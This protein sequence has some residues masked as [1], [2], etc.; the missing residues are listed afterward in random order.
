MYIKTKNHTYGYEWVPWKIFFFT[1]SPIICQTC[2]LDTAF[3]SGY[4]FSN[5]PFSVGPSITGASVSISHLIRDQILM[6]DPDMRVK[7]QVPKSLSQSVASDSYLKAFTMARVIK[8]DNR[9][10]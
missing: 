4:M 2:F 8:V 10:F 9:S 6:S 7:T 1:Q 3:A 5:L